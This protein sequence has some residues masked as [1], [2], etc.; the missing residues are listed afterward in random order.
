MDKKELI[1][2]IKQKIK[3]SR[4]IADSGIGV[5]PVS[6]ANG[7]IQAFEYVLERLEKLVV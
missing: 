4:T 6:I 1:E 5:M 3:K 2:D 7:A